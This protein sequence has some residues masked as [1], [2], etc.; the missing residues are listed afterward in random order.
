MI[1]KSQVSPEY[2]AELLRYM[3]AVVHPTQ[4]CYFQ[5]L[6]LTTWDTT[7]DLRAAFTLW[8]SSVVVMY[9]EW[10]DDVEQ[11]LTEIENDSLP[12]K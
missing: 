1:A 9:P 5:R 12:L 7:G 10:L 4:K 6:F 3:A 11:T 8:R 2:Q